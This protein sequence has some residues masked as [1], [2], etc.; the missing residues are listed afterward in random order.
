MTITTVHVS[1]MTC[2]HCVKAVSEELGA[3]GGVQD[4]A[5]DLV[6]EGTSIVT[7]TSQDALDAAAVRDAVDEAGYAVV[8]D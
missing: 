5:V 3:L 4:V 8:D 2:S 7:V 6:P 1:G